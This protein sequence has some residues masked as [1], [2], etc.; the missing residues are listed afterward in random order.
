M[1]NAHQMERIYPQP[2]SKIYVPLEITGE[3]GKTI[4]T[5]S[6]RKPGMKIFWHLEGNFV[7][8]IVNSHQMALS[9]APGNHTLTIVDEAGNSITTGF[10]ILEAGRK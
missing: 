8:T 10:E 3:R 2:N 7:V 6:H 9:P 5:A 1:V 4:F